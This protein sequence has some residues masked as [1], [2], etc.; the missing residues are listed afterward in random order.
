MQNFVRARH[1]S[2]QFRNG[3]RGPAALIS[4]GAVPIALRRG[5]S[6]EA[7]ARVLDQVDRANAATMAEPAENAS[8]TSAGQSIEQAGRAA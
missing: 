7:I 3:G 5:V 4:P 1:R 6:A 8:P 2:L